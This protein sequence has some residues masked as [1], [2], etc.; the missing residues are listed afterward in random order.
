MCDATAAD[1]YVPAMKDQRTSYFR[2]TLE[3]LVES[4]D[5]TSQLSRWD[6][7]ESVPEPLH[8]SAKKL[9]ERLGTANR[10]SSGKFVGTVTPAYAQKG[11]VP[12]RTDW[13]D[14][15]MNYNGPAF[16]G[17]KPTR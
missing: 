1:C 8:Q 9:G 14:Y 4:L 2:V 5:A 3:A 13:A 16:D 17:W 11:G 15:R 12:G 6:S 7:Q 10:L